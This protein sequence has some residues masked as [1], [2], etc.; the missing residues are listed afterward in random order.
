MR[1]LRNR[2]GVIDRSRSCGL[3]SS[4]ISSGRK[5]RLP[6]LRASTELE[7][8]FQRESAGTAR[9]LDWRS[10][11]ASERNDSISLLMFLKSLVSLSVPSGGVD[12]A[13]CDSI[14]SMSSTGVRYRVLGPELQD[15][16]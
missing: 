12:I 6:G 16:R 3:G 9:T 13:F 8:L 10:T 1:L 4:M 11:W 14:S 5:A 7:R 15:D 2:R